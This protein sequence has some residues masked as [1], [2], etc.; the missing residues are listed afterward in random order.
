MRDCRRPGASIVVGAHSMRDCR[1]SGA[2]IVVGAHF[3]R[4]YRYRTLIADE[5][6]SCVIASLLAQLQKDDQV[7]GD[8]E[9]HHQ[10]WYQAEW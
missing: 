7:D 6:R 2:S 10:C 1:R 4:D 8:E 9:R 5:I 3:M